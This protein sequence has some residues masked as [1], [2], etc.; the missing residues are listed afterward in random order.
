MRRLTQEE[1]I[2]KA[3]EIHGDKY[4]Y[5]KV[6]YVNNSTKVC[7]VCHEKDEYGEEHGEFWQTPNNH[8]Y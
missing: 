2:A 4:D 6:E 7:I 8:F 1:F 3:R 5:S